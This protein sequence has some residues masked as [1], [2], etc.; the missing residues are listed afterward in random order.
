MVLGV[1]AVIKPVPIDKIIGRFYP[2]FGICLIIMAVGVGVG[3][4]VSPAPAVVI[5]L[6]QAD[7]A[8]L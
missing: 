8:G 1:C 5:A 6:V 3:T 7:F 2:V 4:G